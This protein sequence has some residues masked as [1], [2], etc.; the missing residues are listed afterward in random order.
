LECPNACGEIPAITLAIVARGRR[1]GKRY[2][3]R[4][5]QSLGLPP[6][7]VD[8]PTAYYHLAEAH[9]GLGDDSAARSWYR[10]AIAT[11]L[12]THYAR[13]AQSR[14]RNILA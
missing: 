9:R 12:D 10:E 6:N 7:P 2:F 8:L 11:G 13:F 14:L 1:I 5:E 4:W 3:I